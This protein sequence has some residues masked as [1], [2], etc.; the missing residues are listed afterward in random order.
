MRTRRTTP[1]GVTATR[2]SSSAATAVARTG[3]PSTRAAITHGDGRTSVGS[4][5][6]SGVGIVQHAAADHEQYE[7]Q[8]HAERDR[9]GGLGRDD[10]DRLARRRAREPD[11]GQP[12]VA[13]G[14]AEPP[15]LPGE[16]EHRA[17]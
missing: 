7:R 3:S 16:R 15:A 2:R 13:R 11:G 6:A 9:H 12:A 14:G 5:S 8:Q 1:N 4:A 17:A 10:R